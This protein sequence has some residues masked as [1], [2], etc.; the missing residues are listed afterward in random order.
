MPVL[1]PNLGGVVLAAGA[2]RRLGQ[3]KQLVRWGGAELVVRAVD[4]CA[5]VCGAG[6][7]VVTGAHAEQV[8]Q[9]LNSR[10]VKTLFN[11]DWQQGLASS[12]VRGLT[13]WQ[14]AAVAAVLVIHCDQALLN[15]ADLDALTSL[16]Q[17]AP[18]R[19]AA[20][21]YSDVVGV[22]AIIP[23]SHMA[24]LSSLNGDRGARAYLLSSPDLNTI[25]IPNAAFD[26]D[27]AED[28]RLLRLRQPERS[29]YPQ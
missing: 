11:A 20:A 27:T 12:L 2:S 22:P 19:P 23:V 18:Q 10:P 14:Q 28:L 15:A 6:V 21:A 9:A 7:V 25:A 26:V 16:W 29:E 24:D 8:A 5:A 17:T 3:P 1:I 4:T 13:H